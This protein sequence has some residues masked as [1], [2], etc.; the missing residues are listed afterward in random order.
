MAFLHFMQALLNGKW[1]EGE[2]PSVAVNERGFRYGAGIFET[3]R[4]EGEIAPLWDRHIS[5]VLDSLAFLH[6]QLPAHF[7]SEKLL[8]DTIRTIRKNKILGSVRVRITFTHGT[9]GY[10][11]GD[12]KL[13]VLIEA[14]PLDPARKEFNTNGWVL[15]L[16]DQARKAADRLARCKS[17]SALLYIQAAQ[18]AK[19]QKW[20]D[21]LVLNTSGNIADSCIAN[22]F[23]LKDNVLYTT[24]TGQGAVEGVMQSWWID[25]LAADMTVSRGIIVPDILQEADEVF[26]TNALFGIR[27]V[28][29]IGEREY[30]HTVSHRLFQEHLRTIFH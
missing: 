23:V 12:R 27:W 28:G 21:A 10:F 5:R 1:I 14:W 2:T 11:D 8:D 30:G 3:V 24:D 18:Y 19:S 7:C 25:R 4:F 20:N 26:L 15:G 16:F 13:N 29:R 9:G 17:T 6:W 22:I